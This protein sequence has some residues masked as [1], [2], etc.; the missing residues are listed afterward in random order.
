[1]GGF[2]KPSTRGNTR[3]VRKSGD[4]FGVV[5]AGLRPRLEDLPAPRRHFTWLPASHRVS[6]GR[7]LPHSLPTGSCVRSLSTVLVNDGKEALARAELL[8]DCQQV[9]MHWVADD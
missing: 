2:H 5:M 8:A 4:A 6:A 9:S 3:P 7:E 1:M